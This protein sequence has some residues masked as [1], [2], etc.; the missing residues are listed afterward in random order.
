MKKGSVLTHDS[1][2]RGLLQDRVPAV[3]G[4]LRPRLWHMSAP[5]GLLQDRVFAVRG[6][7]RPTG[8]GIYRP[9]G[10]L[11]QQDPLDDI[12]VSGV[13]TVEVGDGCTLVDLMNGGINQAQF[14]NFCPQGGDKTAIRG[15]TTGV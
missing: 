11:L 12:V 14:H 3:R 1:A 6:R 9:Q 2:P 5:R 10:A 4:R 15:T 13:E 8:S 7:L